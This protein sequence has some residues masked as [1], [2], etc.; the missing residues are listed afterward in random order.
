VIPGAQERAAYYRL[1]EQKPA[2]CCIISDFYF[3]GMKWMQSYCSY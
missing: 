3:S 1:P 2:I